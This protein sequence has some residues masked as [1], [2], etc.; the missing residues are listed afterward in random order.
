M[1]PDAV[2]GWAN[3]YSIKLTCK[4][5]IVSGRYMSGN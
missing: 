1:F 4:G 3:P 5:E 2:F